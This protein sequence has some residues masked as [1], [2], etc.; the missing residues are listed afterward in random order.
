MRIRYLVFNAW[1]G[2]GTIST[3]LTNASTLARRGHD[4]EVVSVIRRHDDVRFPHEGVKLTALI[5]LREPLKKQRRRLHKLPSREVPADENRYDRFSELTD[6]VLRRHLGGLEDGA[7]IATRPGLNLAVAR[8]VPESVIRIGQEHL[9][10][11]IHKDKPEQ[12]AAMRKDYPRLDQFVCLTSDDAKDYAAA[13]D[14]RTTAIPNALRTPGEP[15]TPQTLRDSRTIIAAGRLSGQKGFERLVE[16]MALIGPD[17]G[18]RARIYGTGAQEQMLRELIERTGAPVDLMGFT[19]DLDS[20]LRGAGIFAM[21]SRFEGFPMVLLE[22]MGAG[23]PVVTFA[24]RTGCRDLVADAETGL[25]VPQDDVPAFAAGLRA[26]M[27]DADR[28]V[29]MG[30]AGRAV[31]DDYTPD[32]IADRWEALFGEVSKRRGGWLRRLRSR[33]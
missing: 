23:L 1:G 25:I 6:V 7:V 3:T 32:A 33:S 17:S 21:T 13:F 28:R 11:D 30:A 10:L 24:F 26:L 22:G 20:E 8:H 18:W 12:L 14:V 5:D 4:V 2:G 29:A 19:T 9:F 16:A 27:A 31:I 15:A